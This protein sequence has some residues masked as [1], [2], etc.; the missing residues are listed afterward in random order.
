M[1]LK[2]F[3]AVI[4][5]VDVARTNRFVVEI[6]PPTMAGLKP[7]EHVNLMCQDVSFP[8]QN[9]RTSTDDLRQGPTRDIAQGV[10]YGNMNMT[11]ICTPGLPE[12]LFFE[13]WQKLMFNHITWQA[14]Y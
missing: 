7:Q 6:Q 5:R 11:F 1:A 12:K 8:G 2:E 13:A 10:T 14:K 3:I 4:N 9:L